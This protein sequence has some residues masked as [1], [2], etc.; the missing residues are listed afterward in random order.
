M[1]KTKGSP[2]RPS[3]R[4]YGQV[5]SIRFDPEDRERLKILA[6]RWRC[7]E[8]AAVRRAVLDA[9]QRVGQEELRRAAELARKYYASDPEALEWAEFAGDDPDDAG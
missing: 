9:A 8:A 5:K 4:Q 2:G 6:E 3:G 1:G 7:S